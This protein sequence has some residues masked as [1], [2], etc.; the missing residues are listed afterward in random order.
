M[1]NL[2]KEDKFLTISTEQGDQVNITPVGG[3]SFRL[4][5]PCGCNQVQHGLVGNPTL[6]KL[7]GEMENAEAYSIKFQFFEFCNQHKK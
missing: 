7:T 3:G 1:S 5:L 2:E 6:S 4:T